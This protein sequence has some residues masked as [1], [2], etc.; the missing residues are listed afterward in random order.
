MNQIF[1]F[2]YLALITDNT[3]YFLS[4]TIRTKYLPA[5][6]SDRS[7]QPVDTFLFITITLPSISVTRISASRLR[8][9]D[10]ICIIP[11]VGLGYKFISV[12][13][14]SCQVTSAVARC[15]WPEGAAIG[16]G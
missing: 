16:W 10:L 14:I 13:F 11:D 1:I 2:P 4:S 5:C 9:A 6:R 12:S 7:N 3:L 8:I 15:V